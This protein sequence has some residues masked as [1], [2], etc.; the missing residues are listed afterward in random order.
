MS[1]AMSIGPGRC[2]PLRVQRNPERAENHVG[3]DPPA[4][5]R[6]EVRRSTEHLRA[7][8]LPRTQIPQSTCREYHDE[9]TDNA[10]RDEGPD[11]KETP[12][13]PGHGRSEPVVSVDDGHA[14]R[15]EPAEEHDDV[16]G[17]SIGEQQCSA[18]QEEQEG[19]YDEEEPRPSPVEPEDDV[20]A[21]VKWQEYDREQGC[22]GECVG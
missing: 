11:E 19:H 12:G 16:T 8:G 22:D 1:P 6:C 13:R 9:A 10:E 17:S 21:D 2:G 20:A 7:S 15:S 5:R 4:P 18:C 3:F 14:Q